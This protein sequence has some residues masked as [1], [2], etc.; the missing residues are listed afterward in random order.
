VVFF[1]PGY[2]PIPP[3]RYRE[4]YRTEGAAQAGFSGY[5]LSTQAFPPGTARYGWT[6]IF[7]QGETRV[8]TSH[9]FLE[10]H[11]IVQDSMSMG[12]VSTYGRMLET[13]WFYLRCGALIRLF[14]L[15]PQ[16]MIAALYPVL[17]LL[18]QLGLAALLGRFLRQGLTGHLG[19][20]FPLAL[21]A[22]LGL[23]LAVLLLFR[24]IDG[25]VYAYYLA[26][27]YI[28]SASHRGALPP[29]LRERLQAQAELVKEALAS[30]TDE[31]LIVGHSTG[32][33]LAV[34]LSARVLADRGPE[35]RLSLLT[36]GQAIPMV[37][38]LPGAQDLRRALNLCARDQRLT[39][40]DV[41]APGDGA[42]FALCDPVAVSGAAP[43]EMDWHWPRVLSAAYSESLSPEVL[44]RTKWRF[45]RRHIQ[46]ICAFDRPK[47]YDYF[48]ITG[49]P[50][51]LWERFSS[52]RSSMARDVRRLSPHTDF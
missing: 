21:V 1:L 6:S 15:R 18:G 46:Y 33:Q 41:S 31:V 3:R 23:T 27:D 10:W 29:P 13:L 4:L 51:T 35:A 26:Q 50:L 2:D 38:F 16:P 40:I 24:R 47:G 48:A 44:R 28:F 37:S 34:D 36:L 8:E 11:D 5:A 7:T 22:G 19:T 45:F 30:G 39:W 49:G 17:V 20:P 14:R 52:R 9:V 12:I 25:R 42:C 43:P 32:A